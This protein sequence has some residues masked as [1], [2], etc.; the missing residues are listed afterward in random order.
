MPIGVGQ[1]IPSQSPA[2]A[3][4]ALLRIATLAARGVEHDEL[5]AATAEEIARCVGAQA[6]GV[7]RYL[8]EQR[9]V[10]VGAWRA[11]GVRGLP[12]NAELDF[13]RVNS[14]LGR[15]W[16]TRRPSRVDTYEGGRGELPVVMRAVG[17]RSSVA[18]PVMFE[19]EPWGALVA[20]TTEAAPFEAEAEFR[21]GDFAELVGAAIAS[22]VTRERLAA[23]RLRIVEAADE[24]RGR[25]EHKLHEGHQQHLL[26]L[27]LELRLARQHAEDGSELA[28]RLERAFA[29]AMDANTTLRELAREVY[30][31]VLTERG[32]ATALQALAARSTVPVHL[33]EL[34]KGRFP[35]VAEATAYFVVVEGLAN[36]AR[37]ARASE[38]TVA[39]A[40]GGDRLVAELRDDGIGG[41]RPRPRSGLAGLAD[42]AAALGGRLDID[43][44][45]GG[46][47]VVRVEIPLER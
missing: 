8:G 27:A 2:R 26:A 36:A 28:V 17:L 37:H 35:P 34:P 18:A 6:G 40:G 21:V 24:A 39:V 7:L 11:P 10:I 9:A 43:S 14:A 19:D 22:L 46:G 42:R 45:P 15:V 47:T 29:H 13:D 1:E 33:S 38:V 20:A 41:A 44:P 4:A 31:T 16:S 12:V 5:F 3:T 30:P 23:S 32:L 25:L